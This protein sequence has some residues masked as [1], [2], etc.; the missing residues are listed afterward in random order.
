MK[1]VEIQLA[2]I[3][4]FIFERSSQCYR[5]FQQLRILEKNWLKGDSPIRLVGL[6]L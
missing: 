4:I 6:V 2:V 1:W 5:K 3:K